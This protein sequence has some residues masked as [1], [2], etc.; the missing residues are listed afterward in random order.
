MPQGFADGVRPLDD[1]GEQ[2]QG[3]W[4]DQTGPHHQ[5]QAGTGLDLARENVAD[6]PGQRC[7][8]D[9]DQREDRGDGT[10]PDGDDDQ[11]GGSD[12]DAEKLFAR[13]VFAQKG[14]GQQNR[15]QHLRLQDQ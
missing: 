6:G 15:E 5:R 2:Q 12:A 4:D 1:Q 8:E 14:R 9:Q 7:A 10:A 13:R 11:A 3:R